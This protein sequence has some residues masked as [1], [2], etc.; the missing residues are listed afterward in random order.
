MKI[1]SIMEKRMQKVR[2]NIEYKIKLID[3]FKTT[4]E[5]CEWNIKVK[6]EER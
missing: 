3:E 5:Q 2:E 4:L 1:E 6:E